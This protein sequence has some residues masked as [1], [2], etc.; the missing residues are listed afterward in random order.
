VFVYSD[1]QGEL[2]KLTIAP[3]QPDATLTAT[4][5]NRLS[6]EALQKQAAQPAG[7]ESAN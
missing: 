4:G 1:E 3:G 2:V 6:Q 7:T 5:T